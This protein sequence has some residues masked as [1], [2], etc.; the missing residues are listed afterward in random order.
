M[1]LADKLQVMVVDDTQRQ[2]RARSPTR[3]IRWALR[4]SRIAKDGAQALKA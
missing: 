3:S 4:A 1:S 2:P